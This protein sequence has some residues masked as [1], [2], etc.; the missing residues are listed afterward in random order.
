[1]ILA[2]TAYVRIEFLHSIRHLKYHAITGVPI[3]RKL[4][5]GRVLRHLHKQGQLVRLVGLNF[6]V[7][8]SWYYLKRDHGKRRN[9]FCVVH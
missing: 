8:V 1:M 7:T 4:V 5:D 6:P 3:D 2:D 9:S